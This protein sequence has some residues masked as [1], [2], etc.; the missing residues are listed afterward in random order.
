M[1]TIDRS[2]S[3]LPARFSLNPSLLQAPMVPQELATSLAPQATPQ[4]TPQIVLRGL[5]RNWWR[6]LGALAGRVRSR[7]VPDLAVHPANL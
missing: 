5:I 3:K 1:D 4:I 2:D 6:I 7:D